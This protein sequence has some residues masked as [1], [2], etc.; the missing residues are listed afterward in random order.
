MDCEDQVLVAELKSLV[1][2]EIK[3]QRWDG[4]G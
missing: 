1:E 4:H 2:L 3:F